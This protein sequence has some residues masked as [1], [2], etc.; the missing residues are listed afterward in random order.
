MFGNHTRQTIIIRLTHEVACLGVLFVPAFAWAQQATRSEA[1]ACVTCVIVQVSPPDAMA[2]AVVSSG[3]LEGLT[4]V[5]DA[6]DG[7][8]GALERIRATGATPGLV[9][10]TSG[11]RPTDDHLRGAAVLIV[12]DPGTS[13]EALFELRTMTTTVR[14]VAPGIRILI[15]APSVPDRLSAYVD[16]RVE[17]G[18]VLTAPTADELIAASLRGGADPVLVGVAQ[19]DPQVLA[20]FAAQRAIGSEVRAAA[21]LTVEEIVA[22]HQAQRRRQEQL[23]QRTIARGTTSLMFEVPGF[24]APV[25]V[26]A[27]TTIYVQPGATEMEQRDIRVNGAAIAGGS[28]SSPP[29]LPLIEPERV[30]TPPLTI[31]LNEAYRY[32]LAGRERLNGAETY[33][34]VFDPLPPEGGSHD[35]GRSDVG[36]A[37]RRPDP[38]RLKPAPTR[39]LASGRA[40]IDAA[41]FALRRL[42][43]IQ[44]DLRGAIVS[45]EQHEQFGPFP[46]DRETVWLPVRTNVFQMYEGAGHRTPIHRTIHTPSYT[47]NPADFDAQLQ[48][49]Y[50][51]PHLMLRETPLGFRYL[52][53]DR[54]RADGARVVA[55]RAGERIRTAVVGLLVDPNITVP[56]PFAGISYV[57]LNVLDTGAQLN[58][59]FG[60]SYGQL[61][62]SVPTVAGTRWQ[63]HGRAFGIAAS[64]N[65][66][67]FRGGVEQYREN[68]T[69][70]PAHLSAGLVHPLTARLRARVDYELDYTAFDRADTTASTFTVPVDAIVHGLVTA[71][72][73]EWGP[74]TARVWWNPAM[75]QRWRQWGE[76]GQP[77]GRPSDA[78]NDRAFQRVG[79]V[80]SRTL[81]LG[82]TV[83]ARVEV[84]WMHGADLDRFSRYSFGAFDN[85]LHGYP[86]ASVRYDRGGVARSVTSWSA[87]GWRVDA[88]GDLAVVRDPGF[89]NALRGY[90]GVG[91]AVETAG[92]FRTLWSVE[93][94][95]GIRG[96]RSDGG[97]GTQSVRITGYRVF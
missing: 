88:F 52:L 9:L 41:T 83:G 14:A 95:Y 48:A 43:T 6:V 58:A 25:T 80:V 64:Y 51:S 75:R 44:R 19:M 84:A 42:E 24:V 35:T 2:L 53:R 79:T 65:D 27:E 76:E 91:V 8:A 36:A 39:G 3:A 57:D 59:F 22:R 66:R 72:E 97:L 55:P 67:A 28:A 1:I 92:P 18:P 31:T 77:E 94:G 37:F 93:W 56:L 74:W 23:V 60:G 61:S 49:A 20:T 85:R 10:A 33:I 89:G 62:W 46:V 54:D 87:R 90:P 32:R 68:I 47:I 7:T 96:R 34:V 12:G 81:A 50:A 11:T 73:A 15:D 69:Q 21:A 4:V 38:G 40:W 13:D 5:T 29:E 71:V 30:A 78:E 26:T 82:P 17:R 86:T 70:R 63:A 16:G 45:S